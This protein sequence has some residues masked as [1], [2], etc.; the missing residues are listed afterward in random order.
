VALLIAPAAAYAAPNLNLVAT[1]S[2]G[3]CP[4][5]H[6]IEVS[7]TQPVQF[8]YTVENT[9]DT[10]LVN[11]S[12]SDGLH[13]IIHTAPT[14]QPGEVTYLSTEE[15][16]FSD[17]LTL[18][19]RVTATD[20]TTG[21]G[22]FDDDTVFV[23]TPGDGNIRTDSDD[24]NDATFTLSGPTTV[25]AGERFDY[26][27]TADNLGDLPMLNPV[28]S[29]TLAPGTTLIAS[30]PECTESAGQVTCPFDLLFP[31]TP[32]A[33][34]LTVE[35]PPSCGEL[36]AA[37]G[38]TTTD[39]DRDLANNTAT[40][41]ATVQSGATRTVAFWASHPDAV[42]QC[43]AA[44]GGA[45]DLGFVLLTDEMADD[46]IDVDDDSSVED[47]LS[48]TLGVLSADPSQWQDGT[49]RSE[50]DATRLRTGRQVLAA[51]C[52]ALLF[53]TSSDRGLVDIVDD[54]SATTSCHLESIAVQARA[55]SRRA[56]H[57]DV[58]ID[59]GLTTTAT[60]WD[61]PLDPTD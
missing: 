50:L 45:I 20:I 41:L 52:S 40:S 32:L 44:D 48:M 27:L 25:R 12:V 43:L 23:D 2:T 17:D 16:L 1:V 34:T 13:G 33:A 57:I 3:D 21:L 46:D 55:F 53:G 22:Y 28:L 61:D 56:D 58:C 10:E 26:T 59:P 35:A 37:G 7:D 54:L 15:E 51:H 31:G 42:A 30:P 29:L 4:G 39:D 24:A 6:E 5:T 14:L 19:A 60:T 8:C 11:L 47:G 38:V 18:N 36:V 9:G 49:E